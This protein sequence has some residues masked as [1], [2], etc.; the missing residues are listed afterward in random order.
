MTGKMRMLIILL[1]VGV[2]IIGVSVVFLS[3]GGNSSGELTIG[4]TPAPGN[5]ITN[6]KSESSEVVLQTVKIDKTASDKQYIPVNSGQVV[7]AGDNV[8]TVGGSVQN[9]SKVNTHIQLYASGYDAAG[10]QVAWTLDSSG[11][12]GQIGLQMETGQTGSFILHLKFSDK[13]KSIRL[14][15]SNY[16]VT[17]P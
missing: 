14:F 15:C 2:V 12:V 6:A 1:V 16:A 4:I 17:P 5:I 7:N 8:L 9:N 11:I 3:R 13:I 10:K